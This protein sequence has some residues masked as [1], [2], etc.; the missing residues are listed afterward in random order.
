LQFTPNLRTRIPANRL[1][2]GKH[3]IPGLLCCLAV[4]FSSDLR[5]EDRNNLENELRKVYEHKLLS[6]K[7]PYFGSKL[8]FDSSGTLID[9]A[10]AGPWSTCGLLQVEKF[11]LSPDRV[12]IDGKRV[13]LALRSAD[14]DTQHSFL[15]SSVHVTPLV[16]DHRV[17]IVIEVSAL[18]VA[19]VNNTLSQVFQ[20]GQLLERVG[21]YWKPKTTDLK[22]FRSSTP[23]AVVAELEGNRPVYLVNPGVVSP[24]KE[25]HA[26][27]PT[28]TDTARRNKLEGTTVL[29]VAVNEKG[30]PEV[31]EVIRGLGE[32]LDTQALATV[33]GWRFMPAMKNGQPVAVLMSVEVNFRLQ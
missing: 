24:P 29:L 12:E 9:A 28:Y 20:G 33:A 31:L 10:V 6:L 30:F 18:D 17:R 16:T 15:A 11:I 25:I 5:A 21:A 3:L 4:I 27:E 7:N 14:L 1:L 22:A 2:T 8:K 32:G 19:Q 26:P 13:I 23:N